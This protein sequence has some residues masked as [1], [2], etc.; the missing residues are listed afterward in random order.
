M[1]RPDERSSTVSDLADLLTVEVR[2]KQR[3]H[4]PAATTDAE[5][6]A[7]VVR[8]RRSVRVFTDTPIP[9][10]VLDECLDLAMLAPNSSGLQPWEFYVVRSEPTRSKLVKICMGQL[11]ARTAA[12]LIVCVARTDR[13][14]EHAAQMLQEWPTPETPGPARQYYRFIPYLYGPGPLGVAAPIKRA[15]AAVAGLVRPVPRG[16]Y[17]ASELRLWAAKSTALACENLVLALRAHGFDSCM[18]EGFDEARLRRLLDLDDAALPIMVVGA[19]ER[20]PDGVFW[21]QVRFD[22]SQFVH[23]V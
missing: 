5:A 1:A 20:A 16:P 9:P 11:A 4:E 17:T 12:E 2:G 8:S 23:E 21:P 15:V 22:R 3:Y 18:M 14:S 6:F 13:I 7:E 19:G 10:E